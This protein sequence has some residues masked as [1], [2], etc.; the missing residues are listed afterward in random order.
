MAASAMSRV[1]ATSQAQRIADV[2]RELVMPQPSKTRQPKAQ[3]GG[4]PAPFSPCGSRAIA[5]AE[6]RRRAPSG[7]AG[8]EGL[9]GTLT[10]AQTRRTVAEDH[11]SPPHPAMRP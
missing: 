10:P 8:R 9:R 2:V 3:L 7:G 11:Q 4:T 5:I 6:D 1:P